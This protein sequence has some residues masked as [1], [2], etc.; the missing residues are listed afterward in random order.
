MPPLYAIV[1]EIC[2]MYQTL[3]DAIGE[4]GVSQILE[5][6]EELETRLVIWIACGVSR[7]LL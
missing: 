5:A 6:G 3:N 1:L 2:G 7:S 4:A